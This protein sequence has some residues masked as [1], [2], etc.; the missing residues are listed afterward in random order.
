MKTRFQFSLLKYSLLFGM[1]IQG[2]GG[3]PILAQSKPIPTGNGAILFHPDGTSASHWDVT[4][5]LYYGPDNHL[6]WDRLPVVAPYRGHLVDR[7]SFS[8]FPTKTIERVASANTSS[9][10]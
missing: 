9:N 6:H 5:A 10:K 4:R 1:L 2:I 7:H 8:L 3:V